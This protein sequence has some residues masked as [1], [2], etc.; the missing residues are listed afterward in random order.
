MSS[1]FRAIDV[2]HEPLGTV[3]PDAFSCATSD[4]SPAMTLDK[5]ELSTARGGFQVMLGSW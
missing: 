3:G 2:E 5:H 4:S 1:F